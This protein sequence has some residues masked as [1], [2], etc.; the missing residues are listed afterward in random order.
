[1]RRYVKSVREVGAWN[2]HSVTSTEVCA[3]GPD[4]LAVPSSRFSPFVESKLTEKGYEQ[5]LGSW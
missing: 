1:L 2:G 3:P 4:G 5:Q